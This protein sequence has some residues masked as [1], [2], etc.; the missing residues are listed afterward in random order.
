MG[1]RGG[2]DSNVNNANSKYN[3]I[4]SPFSNLNG[5]ATYAFGSPRLSINTSLLAGYTYYPNY[6]AQ[7]YQASIGLGA[8][9]NYRYS[10]KLNLSFNTSSS[11]Q[12]QPNASLAGSSL[13]QSGNSINNGYIYSSSDIGA[14]YQW[15]EELTTVSRLSLTENYYL[16]ASQNSQSGFVEP[17]FTQSV[18]WLFKPTTTLVTD[19]NASSY[20]YNTRFQQPRAVS[21]SWI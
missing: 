13:N 6:A 19:Y 20:N 18:R 2:Y 9:V 4:S 15:S 3:P 1:I 11:Y 7:Q 10:P 12:V 16:L 17:G 5:S 8:N 14:A 21:C